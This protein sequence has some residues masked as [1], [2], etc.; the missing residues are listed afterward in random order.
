MEIGKVDQGYA[1]LVRAQAVLWDWE[2]RGIFEEKSE[3]LKSERDV[4]SW[5]DSAQDKDVSG[6]EELRLTYGLRY[7]REVQCTSTMAV[8]GANI[9]SYL[10]GLGDGSEIKENKSL[11]KVLPEFRN[12]KVLAVACGEHH[13][14]ALVEGDIFNL[15]TPE[16]LK[17]VK[18]MWNCELKIE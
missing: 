16:D 7:T 12:R 9:Q 2:A 1:D 8:T 13:T 5:K 18:D 10:L 4:D 14:L 17:M 15:Y 11:F 6:A 3:G